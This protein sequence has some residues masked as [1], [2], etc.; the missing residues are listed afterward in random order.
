MKTKPGKWLHL[1]WKFMKTVGIKEEK[2]DLFILNVHAYAFINSKA[3]VIFKCEHT[4][5][6]IPSGWSVF[7]T[8]LLILQENNLGMNKIQKD[9]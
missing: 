6:T 5:E 1:D 7:H 8:V 2:K 4:T 3:R 9:V